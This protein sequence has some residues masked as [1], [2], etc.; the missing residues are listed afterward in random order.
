MV[1]TRI[2]AY[3]L[4]YRKVIFIT[5][6]LCSLV[7]ACYQLYPAF[8]TPNKTTVFS[9][10][11]FTDISLITAMLF[12][13]CRLLFIPIL[14]LLTVQHL[15]IDGSAF[16]L[17][18]HSH[19]FNWISPGTMILLSFFIYQLVLEKRMKTFKTNAR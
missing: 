11:I 16:I 15:F 7:P 14:S 19:D 10:C 8:F 13:K 17:R 12:I 3:L 9:H 6:A 5:A 18:P 2:A 4:R 1:D